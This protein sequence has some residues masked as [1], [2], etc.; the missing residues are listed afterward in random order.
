MLGEFSPLEVMD[1]DFPGDPDAKGQR[2]RGEEK[3][4]NQNRAARDLEFSENGAEA[5]DQD[6]PETG[7]GHFLK[8]NFESLCQGIVIKPMQIQQERCHRYDQSKHPVGM[9]KGR[10]LGKAVE[11]NQARDTQEITDPEA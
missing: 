6:E 2:Q 7:P 4:Q 9:G 3:K 8:E 10:D 5:D 11:S 1:E